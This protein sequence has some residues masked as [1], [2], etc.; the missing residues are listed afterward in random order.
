MVVN[1]QKPQETRRGGVVTIIARMKSNST[2]LVG[3]R[4]ASGV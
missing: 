1:V 3:G 4:R 2:G